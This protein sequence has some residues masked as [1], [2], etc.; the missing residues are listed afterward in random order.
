[1][2]TYKEFCSKWIQIEKI[3]H[4]YMT[5]SNYNIVKVSINLYME[6]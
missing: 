4:K 5:T 6:W 3:R 2:W 1:M